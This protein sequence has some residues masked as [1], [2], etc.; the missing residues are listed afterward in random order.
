MGAAQHIAAADHDAER[1][2]EPLRGDQIG[3]EAVDGRLMNPELSGPESASPDSLT[4][5]RR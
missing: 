4:I 2:A 5:T 1:N 3:G